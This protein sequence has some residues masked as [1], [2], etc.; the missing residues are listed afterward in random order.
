MQTLEQLRHRIASAE[1]LG[2]VVGTMKGLAAV[3]IRHYQ[4]VVDSLG[5]DWRTMELGFQALLRAAGESIRI[6][7]WQ[8]RPAGGTTVIAFGSDQGFCG[9]FNSRLARFVEAQTATG[10]AGE[11]VSVL[12]VGRRLAAGL[13]ARGYEP[14]AAYHVPQ[15]ASGITDTARRLLEQL[16][17]RGPLTDVRI[18]AMH[19]HPLEGAAYEPRRVGLLPLDLDWLRRLEQ[20]RWPTRQLPQCLGEPG[21]MLAHLVRRY[22]FIALVKAQAESLAAENAARLAAMQSAEE[23]IRDRLD[24]LQQ[25]FAR[26]RQQ[27]ITQELL[28]IVAGFEALKTSAE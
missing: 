24:E 1:E 21:Q 9:Q 26:Q 3:N 22:V 14:M 8:D 28:E 2:S 13:S 6:G 20:R 4:A 18:S 11:T 12:V 25:R 27:T 10:A 15:L 5:E 17:R 16:Q 19:H 7:P 23:N